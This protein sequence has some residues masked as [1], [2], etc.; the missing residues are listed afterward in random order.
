MAANRGYRDNAL[1]TYA[2]DVAE[3]SKV[4]VRQ[5]LATR[6]FVR[7]RLGLLTMVWLFYAISWV[8]T[9]VFITYWLVQYSGW[10][11]AEAGRLLLVCGGFG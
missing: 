8:A 11:G 4:T 6:G 10:T 5:L 9:N 3:V 2:V 1:K 7:R